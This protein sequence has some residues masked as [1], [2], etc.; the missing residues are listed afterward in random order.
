MV[1]VSVVILFGVLALAL[2][3]G[4]A[5]LGAL[6][7]LVLWIVLLPLRLLAGLVGLVFGA[8]GAVLGAV[9]A[10]VGTVVGGLGALL[11]LAVTGVVAAVVGLVALLP[12][13]LLALPL[14]PLLLLGALLWAVLRG[15]RARTPV[16]G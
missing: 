6:F 9:G 8:I 16:H 2:F 1:E 7:K 14:V 10:A 5:L 11:G 12:L 4:L 13:F 15:A 3:C